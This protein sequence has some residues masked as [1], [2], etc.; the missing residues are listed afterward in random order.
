M[1]HTMSAMAPDRDLD[2]IIRRYWPR[3]LALLWAR[4]QG[5]PETVLRLEY[6]LTFAEALFRLMAVIGLAELRARGSGEAP[7]H[8][9]RNELKKLDRPTDGTWLKLAEALQRDIAARLGSPF[10]PELLR[11]LD[12]ESASGE[13]FSRRL[14]WIVHLRNRA[15]HDGAPASTRASVDRTETIDAALR[16][17]VGAMPWMAGYRIVRVLRARPTGHTAQFEGA[18][19]VF[20]G[21]EEVPGRLEGTWQGWLTEGRCYLLNPDATQALMLSP[22]VAYGASADMPM[23]R[24]CLFKKELRAS[25][26]PFLYDDAVG[27]GFEEPCTVAGADVSF[28]DWLRAGPDAAAGRV[29][30]LSVLSGD[31]T[32]WGVSSDRAPAPPS[33]VSPAIRPA[34]MTAPRPVFRATYALLGLGALLGAAALVALMLTGGFGG[35][36]QTPRVDIPGGRFRMGLTVEEALEVQR[37]CGLWGE[38]V[39]CSLG[40][41]RF[42]VNA[43]TSPR[44]A[45][46]APFRLARDEVSR[47]EYE[48]CVDDGAC[49]SVNETTCAIRYGDDWESGRALRFEATLPDV[50]QVCVTRDDAARY[51]HWVGGRLPMDAE[52]EW[53]ARG[54]SERRLYPWGN[55]YEPD[56]LRDMNDQPSAPVAVSS[57]ESGAS[58]DGVRNLAGN[59]YE[60]VSDDCMPYRRADDLPE[61]LPRPNTELCGGA[62][63]LSRGGSFLSR[64]GSART[65]HRRAFEAT[66]RNDHLGFRCAWD[67]EGR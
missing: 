46:V 41:L 51:C 10:V 62:G 1:A 11:F 27:L 52:W 32:A 24:L 58:R 59:V 2:E 7:S 28:H 35:T 30:G 47:V 61:S 23:S 36:D 31:W 20:T 29:V 19:D 54:G 67:V 34:P 3:P 22:L 42:E 43:S 55:E 40:R 45:V 25:G 15:R 65:T 64:P 50:P 63:G 57:H 60:W 8:E 38:G 16:E 53:A 39:D 66:E 17:V 26:R 44:E 48:A 14:S 21:T 49:A 33:P 37:L 9:V 18:L 56:R 12:T 4:A 5:A 13:P 6:L